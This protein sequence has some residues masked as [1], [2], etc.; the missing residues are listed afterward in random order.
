M[1]TPSVFLPF[2][3]KYCPKYYDVSTVW[4]L[5]KVRNLKY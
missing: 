1:F 4:S 5:P 2:L 3:L